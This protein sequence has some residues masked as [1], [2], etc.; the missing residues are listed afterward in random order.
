VTPLLEGVSVA[1]LTCAVVLPWLTGVFLS[2]LLVPGAPLTLILGHGYLLGQLLVIALLL[3]WDGLGLTLAWTPLALSMLTVLLLAATAAWRRGCEEPGRGAPARRAALAPTDALWLVPLLGFVVLRGSSLAETA[4]LQPLFA[5]DAWMNWAPK[6]VVWFEHGSLTPFVNPEDWLQAPQ[7]TERYTLGNPPAAEYPPGVPL[8]L[9]W[10]MLGA[11]SADHTLIYLGWL[12]LPVAVSLSLW[13]HLRLLACSRPL[14]ALGIYLLISMPLLAT[15]V[16]LPG[17]ADL[18]LG[19]AFSL[20]AMALHG[21][22][23]TGRAGFLGLTLCMALLCALFKNPGLGFGLLLVAGAVIA[24]SPGLRVASLCAALAGFVLVLIGLLAG[25]HPGAVSVVETLPALP[26]PGALP[27]LQLQLSPLLPHLG[28]AFFG[29]G[30]WHLLA[31]LLPATL[32][33][34]IYSHGLT[35]LADTAVVLLLAGVGLLLTVFGFTQYA[36]SVESG[37]TFHRAFLYVAP[38]AVFVAVYCLGDAW[39]ALGHQHRTR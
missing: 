37:V 29:L 7:G 18:W 20:G 1:G 38:L 2:R 17:Y 35:G 34:R 31:V 14:A 5:W 22:Q 25:L 26:L 19:C 27:D 39:A 10:H 13:G 23:S 24:R 9:L 15:H 36:G 16:A 6:A 28:E 4:L 11:D 8:L 12:L 33:L 30:N 3:A 21:W 32:A